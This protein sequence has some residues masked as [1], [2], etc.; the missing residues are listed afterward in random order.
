MYIVYI[1]CV[2][3]VC[4]LYITFPTRKARKPETCWRQWGWSSMSRY[5]LRGRAALARL[6]SCRPR[7]EPR[8][9]GVSRFGSILF[10]LLCFTCMKICFCYFIYHLYCQGASPEETFWINNTMSSG[11]Q[12]RATTGGAHP[13]PLAHALEAALERRVL[14]RGAAQHD[15]VD[16]AA[17][18]PAAAA[19]LA[20]RR[21]LRQLLEEEGIEEVAALPDVL[22]QVVL[23]A[24]AITLECF[25]LYALLRSAGC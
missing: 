23:D 22:R 10:I 6:S 1:V 14:D 17:A 18:G 16:A 8:H 4:G 20:V 15:G 12:L 13:R 25:I 3:S 2:Y 19:R 11:F 24:P 21:L 7:E 9:R 5:D